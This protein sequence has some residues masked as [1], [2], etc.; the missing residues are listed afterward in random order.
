[1]AEQ[2]P[3]RIL[4]DGHADARTDG[5]EGARGDFARP[6]VHR[7]AAHE[8]EAAALDHGVAHLLEARLEGGAGEGHHG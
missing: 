3:L 2:M 5:P 4:A 1:M 6:F 7:Q 8:R